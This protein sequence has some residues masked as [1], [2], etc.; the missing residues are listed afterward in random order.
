MYL[1]RRAQ[2]EQASALGDLRVIDETK[3][4][5]RSAV[6]DDFDAI[7][8]ILLDVNPAD[9]GENIE[10]RRKIFSEIIDD[11]SNYIFVGVQDNTI[12]TTCYLNVIP[13]FTWGPAPYAL[14][15]NVATRAEHRRNG[16]GRK[17]ISHAINFAFAKKGCFK[18]LLSSSQRNARTQAFYK[19]VGFEQS[20]DGYVVYKNF[21][22]VGNVT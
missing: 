22:K 13:N 10:S 21:I 18:I 20:K 7:H 6:V 8:N 12:V 1:K 15:E 5:I 17:C 19:S 11:S 9:A 3:M 4:R 14:I 16:Y 2:N